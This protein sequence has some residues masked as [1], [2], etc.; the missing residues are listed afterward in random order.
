P[1]RS[2]ASIFALSLLAALGGGAPGYAHAAQRMGSVAAQA[3]GPLQDSQ[4]SETWRA[5]D[6]TLRSRPAPP[7]SQ[8]QPQ[9]DYPPAPEPVAPQPEPQPQ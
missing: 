7:P 1:M 4:S 9:P 6:G 3:Y 8:Q 2:N 5:A